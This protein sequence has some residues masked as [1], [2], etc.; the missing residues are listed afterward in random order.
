M[1]PD[2]EARLDSSDVLAIFLASAAV[3]LFQIGLT[4]ILSVVAWYHFAFLAISVVMLGIG[5]P[6]VWLAY[7][8]RPERHLGWLLLASGVCIPVS[9]A[10]I[11][12]FGA[13]LVVESVGYIVAFILPA[14]ISLGAVICLV[15][16]K[17]EGPAI[18]RVY[19]ADLVGAGLAAILLV[20]LMHQF[21]TPELAASAG[22]LPLFALCFKRDVLRPLALVVG[23]ALV[24]TLWQGDLYQVTHSKRYDEKFVQPI[25]ENWSPTARITVF[26]ERG[27]RQM[28]HSPGFSWGRGSRAPLNQ[29]LRHYWLDQDGGAGTPITEF[30]G[31]LAPLSNL[32]YDVTTVGYQLRPPASVA[33]IGAGGG[34]DILSAL[35]AGASD[36]DAVELNPHIITAVSEDFRELSGDVYHRP[37][38]NA[39]ASE[40]RSFLTHTDKR[41]DLIQISLIDSWAATAAGAFALAENNLYT[42]E[43]FEL[44]LDKLTE[45]GI[46]STS[47][48]LPELPRLVL[49]ARESL[50]MSGVEDPTEHMVVVV[51]ELAGTLLVSRTPFGS[52]DLQRLDG[53]DADRGFDRLYPPRAGDVDAAPFL[54]A[55]AE[56]SLSWMEELGL[57]TKAPTDD[58][59]YFFHVVSPFGSSEVIEGTARS[60]TT[61]DINLGST[62][63][64][65]QA[66]WTVTILA[67]LLFLLPFVF[68]TRES[69]NR[70]RIGDLALASVYFAAIGS[71]F[72]LFENVL[73]QRF[74]LYLGHP[75]YATTVV[76]ATLL[77]GMGIG[78]SG[79]HRV[80][81]RG[82]QRVGLLAPLALCGLAFGLPLLFATTLGW[83]HAVRIAVSCAVLLPMGGLLGLFFPLGMLRFGDT[84]KPWFWAINGVF[85]VV[86]SVL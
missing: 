46:L 2:S 14:T 43:A 70:E 66:M 33:I 25:Y 84:S 44:Y 16:M 26:D 3:M 34:R 4:R 67:I 56:N 62:V 23:L 55:T 13:V 53:I 52:E 68:R 38:V 19:A 9:V 8:K 63:V 59:P 69:R 65:K 76:I 79:A 86:A 80:G 29:A 37:G 73:V 83:P 1:T 48:W 58:S 54:V 36:I 17:A 47:R 20:P 61:R 42:V 82:L 11:V 50:V 71:G 22:L 12:K 81:V 24:G 41:F 10:L 21:P 30:T 18:T 31:D 77:I 32:L 45:G 60:V 6:G 51:A 72:M 78:A 40:G 49:L 7:A 85:G 35:V 64:L 15:L 75:S 28:G 39:I 27:Y 74:V 5:V 57:Y